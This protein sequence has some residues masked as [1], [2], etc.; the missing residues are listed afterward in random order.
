[1]SNDK[2]K[3]EALQYLRSW[4]LT[5]RDQS[6][7][8]VDFLPDPA[9]IQELIAFNMDGNFDRVMGL[10]GCIIGLEEIHNLSKRRE[11]FQTKYSDLQKEFDSFVVNNRRLFRPSIS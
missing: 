9:L 6:K 7:R 11:E 2:I 10:V 5:E 3:W 8:N 1:M 4:L